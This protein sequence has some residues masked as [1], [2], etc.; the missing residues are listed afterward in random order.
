MSIK[1]SLFVFNPGVPIKTWGRNHIYAFPAFVNNEVWSHHRPIFCVWS[2]GFVMAY[3]ARVSFIMYL[4]VL[5]S[6]FLDHGLCRSQKMRRTFNLKWEKNSSRRHLLVDPAASLHSH[7]CCPPFGGS[8]RLPTC[9]SSW[10]YLGFLL[11]K[12]SSFLLILSYQDT[13]DSASQFFRLTNSTAND[14]Y[15]R[16]FCQRQRLPEW[17][18]TTA[19]MQWD[20]MAGGW[21]QSVRRSVLQR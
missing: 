7:P 5:T 11:T 9:P 16:L 20:D 19:V 6:R 15:Y 2:S 14:V 12:H 8:C 13:S 1:D 4:I 17:T 18:V 10:F 3:E 21:E